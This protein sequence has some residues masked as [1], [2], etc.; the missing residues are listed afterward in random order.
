MF[1]IAGR[2]MCSGTIQRRRYRASM[3]A[4]LYLLTWLT[5]IYI[6]VCPWQQCL[7]E[8]ATLHV[9]CPHCCNRDGECLLRNAIW[10]FK[11]NKLCFF[12]RFNCEV[13]PLL[14]L[15][16]PASHRGGLGSIPGQSI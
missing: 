16:V 4:R 13:F 12:L 14:R 6:V 3:A 15:L 8:R 11:Q 10:V 9:L 2:G 7:R 1:H 5:A